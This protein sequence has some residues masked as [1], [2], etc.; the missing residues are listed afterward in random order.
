MKKKLVFVLLGV[1]LIFLAASAL[2]FRFRLL[3]TGRAVLTPISRPDTS[4]ELSTSLA[5]AGIALDQPPAVLGDKITASV[6]GV[7][8]IFATEKD[9]PTQ[10]RTLQLILPRLRIDNKIKEVDLRFN[11][12]IVRT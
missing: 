1:L 10:V 9:L 3:P 6:S 7:L 11:K 4:S 2:I 12:V 5:Q 8:V